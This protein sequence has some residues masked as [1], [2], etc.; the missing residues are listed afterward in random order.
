M[1]TVL[2][3]SV[4]VLEH[5]IGA[6]E[7]YLHSTVL[8]TQRRNYQAESPPALKWHAGDAKITV[9]DLVPAIYCSS[10]S[11]GISREAQFVLCNCEKSGV[12]LVVSSPFL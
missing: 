11:A 1:H 3:S 4:K 2:L 6:S 12:T 5:V 9:T 10:F 8:K 7:T